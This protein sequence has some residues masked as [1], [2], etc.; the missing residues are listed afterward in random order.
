MLKYTMNKRLLRMIKNEKGFSL[1]E[2]IISIAIL[3]LISQGAMSLM[4]FITKYK[5]ESSLKS[6]LALVNQSQL[7]LLDKNIQGLDVSDFAEDLLFRRSGVSMVRDPDH[8][9]TKTA[10]QINKFMPHNE[11]TAYSFIT[12]SKK[13]HS[14]VIRRVYISYCTEVSDYNN[15]PAL[16]DLK[17]DDSLFPVLRANG[18]FVGVFCCP[19][20]QPMCSDPLKNA[21]SENTDYVVKTAMY[22]YDESW[23]LKSTKFFPAKGEQRYIN[24]QGFFIYREGDSSLIAK[25]YT[26]WNECIARKTKN[27][28]NLSGCKKRV[29]HNLKRTSKG[30]NDSVGSGINDFGDIGQ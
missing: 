8:S 22:I 1:I 10:D 5:M 13:T 12:N 21:M 14:G 4:D 3:G 6:S 9:S 30:F 27:D 25:S 2:V 11:F 20:S 18:G 19:K 24:S 26:V 28:T 7:K 23:N 17:D 29:Y 16:D 15:E